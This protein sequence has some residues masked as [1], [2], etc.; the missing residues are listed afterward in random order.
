[1][2][3][4]LRPASESDLDFLEGMSPSLE[5]AALIAQI[6]SGRLH[7]I[8]VGST[9]VGFIKSCILWS[10][11]PF[12]EVIEIAGP[13]RK[14]GHGRAAVQAW[15]DE[16]AGRGFDLVITSTHADGSAQHFWRKLGYTDCG[17]LT[18]RKKPTEVFFEHRITPRPPSPA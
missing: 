9:P 3:V 2:S 10:T 6:T 7:V 5:H 8:G 17:V 12:L 18:V 11:L 1:M 16:M 14:L 4:I 15:E 13:H